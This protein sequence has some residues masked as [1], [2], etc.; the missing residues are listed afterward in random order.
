[1]RSGGGAGTAGGRWAAVESGVLGN[2]VNAL[3]L[4]P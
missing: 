1:M 3:V 4:R 2:R